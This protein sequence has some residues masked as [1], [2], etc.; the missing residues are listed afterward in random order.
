MRI[1]VLPIAAETFGVRSMSTFV[2]TS[3]IK[4]LIDPGTALG[5]RYGL[6][7]HPLEYRALESSRSRIR[8]VSEVSDLIIV[9]HY[10]YDHYTPPFKKKDYLWTW[11]DEEETKIVFSEKK[12]I[13][14][15]IESNIN[16]S[17]KVR[18]W[19][20]S[21]FL[22][23]I[24]CEFTFGDG[25]EYIFGNTKIKLL[26]VYHGE[27][28]SKLGYVNIVEIENGEEKFMFLPDVQ[29]PI[30]N[31]TLKVVLE[32]NPD[33]VYLGGPP[34][35]LSG[36]SIDQNTINKGLANMT[37]LAS[38]V[39]KIIVDH[40]LMRNEHWQEILEDVK[41]RS[42]NENVFSAASYIGQ[43]SRAL[44]CKRKELYT[45][46]PVSDEFKKWMRKGS[47][48]KRETPPPI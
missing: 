25:R 6:Y 23:G 38:K 19:Y 24:N 16:H 33:I 1:S 42:R 43:T 34:T 9:T 37:L 28:N 20:L 17:Q 3:D 18:G 27:E 2:R 46:Y 29:G 21:K 4:I 44:E 30:S 26:P 7:P 41:T 40:H 5:F 15:D 14:K 45:K 48:Y 13:L 39:K 31:N 35:Y 12:I 22:K 32:Y 10:H 8:K 36:F 11:S 47:K